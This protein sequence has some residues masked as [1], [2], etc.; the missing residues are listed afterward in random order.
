CFE[1]HEAENS[2]LLAHLVFR[3]ERRNH[4]ERFLNESMLSLQ[5][6]RDALRLV[7]GMPRL[8]IDSDCWAARVPR[9][10]IDLAVD[11]RPAK[12]WL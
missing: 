11:T 9:D 3:S 2:E 10:A 12:D 6:N 7:A 5:R 1:R 4:C 8:Q